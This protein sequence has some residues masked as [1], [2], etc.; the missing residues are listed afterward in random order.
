MEPDALPP[1]A[2]EKTEEKGDQKM[3]VDLETSRPLVS[4]DPELPAVD[5]P[6]LGKIKMQEQKE[7]NDSFSVRSS[8]LSDDVIE[9]SQ[10]KRFT[11]IRDQTT[12][13]LYE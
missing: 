10:T 7:K 12:G 13:K 5:D 3:A 11:P 1:K 2:A 4:F 8:E 6:K 9:A